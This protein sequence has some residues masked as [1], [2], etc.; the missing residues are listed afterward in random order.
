MALEEQKFEPKCPKCGSMLCYD[1][2]TLWYDTR[3]AISQILER[4]KLKENHTCIKDLIELKTVE[5]IIDE[6]INI[7][8]EENKKW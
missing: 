6:E 8:M 1:D 7:T 5:K 3:K 4:I 2:V